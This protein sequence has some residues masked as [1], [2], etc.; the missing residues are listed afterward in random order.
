MTEEEYVSKYLEYID[1]LTGKLSRLFET[2][3]FTLA[4]YSARDQNIPQGEELTNYIANFHDARTRPRLLEVWADHN[5]S[6]IDMI[7]QFKVVK[8]Y[9][10]SVVHFFY[11]A[12]ITF[13]T[14]ESGPQFQRA[15]EGLGVPLNANRIASYIKATE[16][17]LESIP[18]ESYF[19]STS[20]GQ[21][22]GPG[23][24]VEIFE[25]STPEYADWLVRSAESEKYWSASL[26]SQ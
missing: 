7:G 18:N 23:L 16:E 13:Y 4:R 6:V 17:L 8:D 14:D 15:H 11:G 26:D 12:S 5:P 2:L 10:N 9:R 20:F 25:E 3:M 19:V 24:K 22:I 1:F 21:D